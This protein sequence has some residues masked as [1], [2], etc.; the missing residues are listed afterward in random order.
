MTY[1]III[2]IIISCL[3]SVLCICLYTEMM[4]SVVWQKNW[5]AIYL[6]SLQMSYSMMQLMLMLKISWK[7]TRTTT[8]TT[9]SLF[10]VNC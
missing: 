2:I 4:K 5:K 6:Q 8:T 9:V 10:L 7:I 1:L 3:L